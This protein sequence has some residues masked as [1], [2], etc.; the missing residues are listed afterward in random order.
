MDNRLSVDTVALITFARTCAIHADSLAGLEAP[1][2]VNTGMQATAAAVAGLH[3]ASETTSAVMADRIRDTSLR[4]QNAAHH[5]AVSESQRALAL[6]S[7]TG[8]GCCG[9]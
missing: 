4:V 1:A 5:V 8:D 3:A 2:V 6:R 7:Q 9:A